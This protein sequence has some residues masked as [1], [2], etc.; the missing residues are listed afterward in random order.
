MIVSIRTF[1][2]D[3]LGL[4]DDQKREYIEFAKRFKQLYKKEFFSDDL[5][6]ILLRKVFVKYSIY[7]MNLV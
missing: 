4:D 5:T 6:S 2:K 7:N 1:G 3:K